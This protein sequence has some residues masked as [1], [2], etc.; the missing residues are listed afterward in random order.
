MDNADED[1][2]MDDT[3]CFK[4]DDRADFVT[5][6]GYGLPVLY[7]WAMAQKQDILTTALSRLDNETA[8][9][10][11]SIPKCVSSV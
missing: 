8:T 11:D 6:V 2:G 5:R 10:M 1:E 3:I 7:F 4:D 9:T